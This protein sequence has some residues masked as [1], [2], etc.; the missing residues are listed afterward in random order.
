VQSTEEQCIEFL[1]FKY[2]RIELDNPGV[3][4]LYPESRKWFIYCNVHFDVAMF[5]LH[6][7]EDF[8]PYREILQDEWVSVHPLIDH[9]FYLSS[10][11]TFESKEKVIRNYPSPLA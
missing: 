11:W 8:Q 9:Y 6:M 3:S 4:L 1:D 5:S 10:G 7:D 2:G